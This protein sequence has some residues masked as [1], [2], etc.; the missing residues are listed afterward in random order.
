MLEKKTVVILT[1]PYGLRYEHKLYNQLLSI[2]KL[3]SP[4]L[5]IHKQDFICTIIGYLQR[6]NHF[7]AM[8]NYFVMSDIVNN[9]IPWGFPEVFEPKS[10]VWAIRVF[11]FSASS[12]QEPGANATKPNNSPVARMSKELKELHDGL[13][14]QHRRDE[15]TLN[16]AWK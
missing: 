10:S 16:F 9:H 11:S 5:K 6:Y 8:S 13:E 12:I 1:K 2:N 14:N 15:K 4:Q 7:N 3:L